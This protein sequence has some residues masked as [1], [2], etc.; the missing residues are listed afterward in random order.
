[1]HFTK[2][3]Y[4]NLTVLIIMF[5]LNVPRHNVI[6]GIMSI[7]FFV[8][9]YKLGLVLGLGLEFGLLSDFSGDKIT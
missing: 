1:M 5:R 6:F 8:F 3:N 7:V 4:A 2:T 9:F